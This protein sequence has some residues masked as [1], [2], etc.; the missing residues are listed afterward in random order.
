MSNTAL[1]RADR[2]GA[3]ASFLCAVH[4]ALVPVLLG[5][6]PALGLS[7][8]DWVEIDEAFVVFASILG[9]TTLTLGWRRHRVF[10]AWI[11]LLLG[12]AL[13]WI[14][15]FSHVHEHILAHAVLMTCGGLLVATAHF[16]NMRLTHAHLHACGCRPVD[17]A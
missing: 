9:V 5:V 3:A 10:R 7:L 16:L 12:L 11:V 14:G 8:G 1:H 17:R 15:A 2:V 6:L 4:C 13:L